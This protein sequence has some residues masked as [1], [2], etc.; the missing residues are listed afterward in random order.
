MISWDKFAEAVLELR[1]QFD[2]YRMKSQHQSNES[3][4][5]FYFLHD[6]RERPTDP[7]DKLFA[8]IGLAGDVLS[9]DWEVTP[10][11]N[12]SVDE[13]YRRFAL[14]HLT[15]KRQFEVFSFGRNH[16]LP[17]SSQLESLPSWVPDLT[18][19]DFTA[20]LPKLEYLSTNY[21]D[22]RYD[23]LKEFELRKKYFHE[24]IKI[25]HADLKYPWWAV[26]R[27][28]DFRPAQIAFSNVKKLL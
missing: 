22:M 13:A 24:G 16:D 1:H 25:Y 9:S 5:N 18:R 4:E 14:W 27:H 11:Y 20:P 17:L 3:I 28:S 8:L 26:G 19:S 21:I 10:N 15:R 12:L 7:R 2:S 23:V 6:M